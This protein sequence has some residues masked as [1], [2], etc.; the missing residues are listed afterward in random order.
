MTLRERFNRVMHFQKVDRIPF[1]EFGYW[2]ETLPTWH[3]QGLPEEIDNEAKA[4]EYFGIE[5]WGGVPVNVE[6]YPGP[7]FEPGVVE[8][9]EEYITTRDADG[10]ITRI[11]KKGHR[12][13]P[14]HISYGLKNRDDWEK[15]KKHLD[16]YAEGRIS[17]DFY[18]NLE[19]YRN[20]D[21]VL[22]VGI[23]SMIGTP[24]NWIGFENIGLMAYDD[25][26][27]LDE[28][29]ETLCRVV[30]VVL[31][32]VLPQVKCDWAHGWEDICFNSGPI[33]SPKM[34]DKFVVPRYARITSIL[35]KYGIDVVSIDCDGNIMPILDGFMEGGIN[36]MFPL[37][38]HGG[39]DPVKIREKYGRKAL[40]MGGV[41]KLKLAMDKKTIEQEL[42]RIEPVVREGGFIPFV[43]HRVPP[44][45]SLENYKFYLKLKREMFE[46]GCREPQY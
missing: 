29:I 41:D 11:N 40:L 20:R 36:T 6:I 12:S 5:N 43:D 42:R 26:E 15:F 34:F 21:Y 37:E 33:I 2:D 27:L 9:T 16:P 8:E 7:V 23:S 45:V 38:V 44:T 39:S 31:E 30:E 35:H 13:I 1:F 19:A 24:R 22:T 10:G 46:A 28:I 18:K 25:P 17:P 3:K 4:Y 32:K 14:Q